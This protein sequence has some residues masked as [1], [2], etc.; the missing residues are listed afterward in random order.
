[1]KYD[2]DKPVLR[3][4]TSCYK[5]DLREKIFGDA[6]VIPMWVADMDF[7][8][9]DFILNAIKQRLRHEV[10]GYTIIP[11]SFYEAII[12]WL[13]IRHKWPVLKEWI[14]FSPGVVPSINMLIMALTN[15]GDEIIIQ[16]PVYFPFY[17]SV[18]NHGRKLVTNPLLYKDGRY[19]MDFDHL[20]SVAG[21]DVKMFILCNP[22]NPT[23][24]VWEK[25]DLLKLAEICIE[26]NIIL[27]SDE[28]H[29]DLI[30]PGNRHI[31]VA[32]LSPEAAGITI[33]CMAPSKTFN[34]AGLSTSF[35]VISNPG[36]KQKYETMLNQINVG[37]GNIFGFAATTTAYYE[38]HEWLD[39]LMQYLLD[40]LKVLDDFIQRNIPEIR[41]VQPRATFLVWLDCRGIGMKQKDMNRF[42]IK[43]AGLGLSDG[44]IFGKEGEGF[45]RINIAC[46]R[47]VLMQALVQLK[48]A[49]VINRNK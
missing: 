30:F 5:Y 21:K 49:V 41:V 6:D 22:H 39:Q 44:L 19:T 33:T 37:S 31:P 16:T 46:P 23:G 48:N 2:F 14:S 43:E 26:R 7:A 47:S 4:N 28:I 15:P 11:D 12:S 3:E 38:G 35:V 27:L 8:T 18:Q 36:L 34:M 24:N 32:S 29:C 1:M 40:N 17:S 25:E 45:Q 9:P 10:M 13:K 42:M 20:L